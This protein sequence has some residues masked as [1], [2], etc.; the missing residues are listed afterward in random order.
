MD[1]VRVSG[2]ERVLAPPPVA[3]GGAVEGD[4]VNSPTLMLGGAGG[5]V[6]SLT[7]AIVPAVETEAGAIVPP[8]LAPNG[9]GAS[10]PA[11]NCPAAVPFI[12]TGAVVVPSVGES[13]GVGA[14]VVGGGKKGVGDGV[15][16]L[17]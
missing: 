13:N 8:S 12:A 1:S 7:G 6:G 3:V 14:V 2:Q 5:V 16:L 4:H 9:V 10:V 15:S 11:T 17:D